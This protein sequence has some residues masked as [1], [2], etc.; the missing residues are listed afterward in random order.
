MDIDPCCEVGQA[1]LADTLKTYARAASVPIDEIQ[2]HPP[3]ATGAVYDCVI[4]SREQEI[5]WPIES[6]LLE[7]SRYS[8]VLAQRAEAV[9]QELLRGQGGLSPLTPSACGAEG[10]SSVLPQTFP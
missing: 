1:Y 4:L 8:V 2:W 5:Y 3:S 10:E 7:D 6:R 9:V